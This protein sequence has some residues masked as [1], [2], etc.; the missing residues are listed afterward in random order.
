MP[1]GATT[2]LG[3][4]NSQLLLAGPVQAVHSLDLSNRVLQCCMLVSLGKEELAL[5]VAE[6]LNPELCDWLGTVFEAFGCPQQALKLPRLSP[7][8][9]MNICIKVRALCLP[10]T[11]LSLALD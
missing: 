4:H 11:S 6:S 5:Q 7:A 9:K 1:N 3:V 10:S 2:I 8:L